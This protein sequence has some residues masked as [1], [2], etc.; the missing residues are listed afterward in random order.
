MNRESKERVKRDTDL[1]RYIPSLYQNESLCRH[2]ACNAL[3]LIACDL[4]TRSVVFYCKV[5]AGVFL[6]FILK[7]SVFM[8]Q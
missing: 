7:S 6:V 2:T 4:A 5:K 8:F 3:P 1:M